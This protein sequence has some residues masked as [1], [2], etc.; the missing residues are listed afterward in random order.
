MAKAEINAFHAS[1][2]NLFTAWSRFILNRIVGYYQQR[3]T[4]P[5]QFL[6]PKNTQ[7]T[8]ESSAIGGAFGCFFRQKI[9]N[10]LTAF[11]KNDTVCGK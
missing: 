10:P 4:T 1:V 9:A 8:P 3:G 11:L 2:H 6:P 5:M 7:H